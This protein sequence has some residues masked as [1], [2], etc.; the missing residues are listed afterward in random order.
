MSDGS[1]GPAALPNPTTSPVPLP[2][3]IPTP[4]LHPSLSP[5]PAPPS[6]PRVS[7]PVRRPCPPA[8]PPPP[9]AAQDAQLN[10]TQLNST[11]DNSAQLGCGTNNTRPQLQQKAACCTIPDGGGGAESYPDF[12]APSEILVP[13]AAQRKPAARV[14][15]KSANFRTTL[16]R[17]AMK[18]CMYG[19]AGQNASVVCPAGR[20]DSVRTENKRITMG[21]TIKSRKLLDVPS[22]NIILGDKQTT[23]LSELPRMC[24]A[25]L[26]PSRTGDCTEHVL[27][28]ALQSPAQS[29]PTPPRLNALPSQAQS[30]P[31]STQ[32]HGCTHLY[33]EKSSLRRGKAAPP[34]S[35]RR[36]LRPGPSLDFSYSGLWGAQ[37][38]SDGDGD[39]DGGPVVVVAA[40]AAAA[41]DER[42]PPHG[43][44]AIRCYV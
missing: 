21:L 17:Y 9:P 41:G 18:K 10:S 29:R 13:D 14:A 1:V 42:C 6:G 3:P 25:N 7:V 8:Q 4:R 16:G 26:H 2:V 37:R 11:Q 12:S 23:R 24:A 30:P 33:C 31:N 44:L 27:L 34:P 28:S 36:Q 20:F 38:R 5:G 39:G 35:L 40:A 43:S 32:Q 15:A 22:R 19:G